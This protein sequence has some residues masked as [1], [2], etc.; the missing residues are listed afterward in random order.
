MQ[1]L[2]HRTL[3]AQC[4]TKIKKIAITTLN[5]QNIGKE[6][7]NLSLFKNLFKKIV[8]TDLAPSIGRLRLTRIRTLKTKILVLLA[9]K[10]MVELS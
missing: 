7:S 4:S 6:E 2:T 10:R 5:K 9:A 3:M 1:M 8:T